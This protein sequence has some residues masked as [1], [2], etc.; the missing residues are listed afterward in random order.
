MIIRKETELDVEAIF[1]ITKLAFENHP[2]SN[3][4]EQ[5]I[6]NALRAADALTISLVAE[7]DGKLVGHIAF[8]PITFSDESKNWYG[9][10]PISV[11]PD[12]QKQGIGT[13]LV[14]EGLGQLKELGAAGC[15]L[16]GDPNFYERFGFRSPDK[17]KHEGVPQENFLVLSF[18][19]RIP[20]G[21]VQFHSA[22][23]AT[24]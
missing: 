23:S 24:E 21:T 16:V 1:D 15:V 3:N 14:N 5:F 19:N 8:S 10:G 2:Y 12:Y 22:F 6:I 17:L 20:E 11:M 18:C 9:L 7:I 13:K 4:T